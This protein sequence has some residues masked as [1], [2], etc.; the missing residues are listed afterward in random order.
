[1]F[2]NRV[3]GFLATIL[4]VDDEAPIRNAVRRFLQVKKHDVFEAC[5][6]REALDVLAVHGIDL[7]VVDL[8]MPRMSGIELID[9]MKSSYPETGVVVI[10]AYPD[11]DDI[12]ASDS[13]VV[14]VLKKPFELN[15]LAE[16]VDLA[17]R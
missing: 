7:A 3:D 2:T 14:A 6:G 5:D 10:S 8:M 12:P 1:M 17:L 4:V 11:V 16:A 9:C 15:E 13:G